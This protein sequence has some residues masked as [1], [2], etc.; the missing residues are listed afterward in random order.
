MCYFFS[1]GHRLS[2]G[3]FERKRHFHHDESKERRPAEGPNRHHNITG[4]KIYQ[5]FLSTL[6]YLTCRLNSDTNMYMFGM[7]GYFKI[8]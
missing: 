1:D 2:D 8:M 7:Q 6:N 4:S 3:K 5:H